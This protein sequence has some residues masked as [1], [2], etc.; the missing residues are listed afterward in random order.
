MPIFITKKYT[1]CKTQHTLK[2]DLF[3]LPDNI[4]TGKLFSKYELF[5]P[6]QANAS[7]DLSHVLILQHPIPISS[8]PRSPSLSNFALE[9]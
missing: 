8:L 5:F 6:N 2:I 9:N 4:N 1:Q 7:S 3:E